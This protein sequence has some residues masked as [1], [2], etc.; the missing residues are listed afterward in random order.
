MFVCKCCNE[1]KPTSR[2]VTVS[3]IVSMAYPKKIVFSVFA[4]IANCA[5]L[6]LLAEPLTTSKNPWL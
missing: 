6:Y 3:E 4:G 1:S 2:V 5:G